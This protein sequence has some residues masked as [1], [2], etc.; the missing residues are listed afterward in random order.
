M[1]VLSI[2]VPCYNEELVLPRTLE[3]LAGVVRDLAEPCEIILVD[4][5][6]S[7]R[8]WAIIAAAT[9]P[10]AHV[11]GVRLARNSGQQAALIAG[12]RHARG[13]FALTL[14]ADLQDPPELARPMLARARADAVPIV[15]G[16]RRSRRG[17]PWLKRSTAWLFHR[18]L[19]LLARHPIP[20]DSGDF[21]LMSRPALDALLARTDLHRYLRAVVSELG[22]PQAGIAFDRPP[23]AAGASKYSWRALLRIARHALASVIARPATTPHPLYEIRET[24]GD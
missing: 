2:V 22:L 6:S 10:P 9:A 20:V 1:P 3:R 12:L 4:D 24:S 21:R 11:R 15:Y 7:D 8:T 5:G 19:N 17:E 18:T 14:D 13:D 23:R 16:V